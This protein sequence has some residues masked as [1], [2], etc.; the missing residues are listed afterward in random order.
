MAVAWQDFPNEELLKELISSFPQEWQG[1]FAVLNVKESY[2]IHSGTKWLRDNS[3]CEQKQSISP[4]WPDL[5]R[6][7]CQ[8]FPVLANNNVVFQFKFAC[9]TL[10]MQR[11]ILCFVVYH[12]ESIPVDAIKVSRP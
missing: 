6:A 2:A 1:L 5:L 8:M 11:N 9:F 3:S 4:H 12:S 10:K 7:L